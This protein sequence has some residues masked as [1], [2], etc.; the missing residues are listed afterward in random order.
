MRL[1]NRLNNSS[2]LGDTFRA[3]T[4]CHGQGYTLDTSHWKD[5]P[6]QVVGGRT[7]TVQVLLPIGLRITFCSAKPWKVFR[8]AYYIQKCA[9][10]DPH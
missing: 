5:S 8:F 2:A 6:L 10:A 7:R 4:R 1:D 9:S 3:L